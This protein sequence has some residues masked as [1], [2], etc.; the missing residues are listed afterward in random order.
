MGL[1]DH[2]TA[3]ITGANSGIGLATAERFIAEG[4]TGCSS[5]ADGNPNWPLPQPN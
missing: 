1:L 5:P 2:K 4:P 3:V